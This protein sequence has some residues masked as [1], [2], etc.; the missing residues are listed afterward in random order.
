MQKT[1][2]ILIFIILFFIIG[3]FFIGLNKNTNYNTNSLIGKK[4]TNIN[5]KYFNENKFFTENDLKKNNFTLINFW[6]SWCTPCRKEHPLLIKLSK[7]KNLKLLGVN[8][9]DKKKQAQ[10]FLKELG[11]PYDFLTKDEQGKSSVKFG[12]YGIPES[13][14]VNK[15]LI[16]LKKF[17]GPLSI[18]DLNSIK[19]TIN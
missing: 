7:E 14:L 4:I 10:F 12:V 15:N 8:F 3:V 11:N 18:N 16:I 19:E 9:K 1:I 6:A 2:K 5:L 17:I 13:I